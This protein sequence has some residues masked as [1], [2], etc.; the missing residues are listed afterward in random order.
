MNR[1]IAP[2][3]IEEST[4]LVKVLKVGHV[5]FASPEIQIPDL[6]IAP[7]QMREH[8]SFDVGSSANGDC[9]AGKA[10]EMAEIVSVAIVI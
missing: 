1:S 3:L 7:L 10:Y 9:G 5:W 4:C 6:E 8:V 2:S